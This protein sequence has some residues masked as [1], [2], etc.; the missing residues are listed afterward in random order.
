MKQAIVGVVVGAAVVGGIWFFAG[1]DKTVASVG[2][3]K[4]TE[5]DFY[6]K[7]EKTQGA[8]DNMH[9]LID[10]IVIQHQ[11]KA[12]SIDVTDKEVQSELDSFVKDKFN[13][14]KAQ[15]ETALKDYNM[16]IDDLK[17]D[18]RVGLLGQKIATKDVTISDQEVKDYYDKNKETMGEQEQLKARH[19]LVKDEAKANELFAKLKANPNDFEKL[20]KENSED[21]GS[22]DKG[23]LL[24]PFGK[25]VMVP[26]FEQAAFAAKV[27]ELVGPVKSEF[28]YHIIQVME[29]KEA[30]V[31]TLDEVKEKVTK[32][33]KEQKAKPME[34]LMN[35]LYAKEN[36]TINREGYK[37]IL[38]PPAAQQP[39]PTETSTGTT[40]GAATQSK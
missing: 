4:I 39:A 32:T 21:P 30:K 11:A 31:P 12:L 24:E 5:Q 14:D 38:N 27:N 33:L 2:S 3:D 10:D 35:E 40:D 1:Q 23:G 36:I 13:N 6:S 29:H 16:T 19:I 8:K 18:I 22:K 34:E 26:E 7:L 37:D 17:N 20:A 25:G 9:K 15:L 28:G